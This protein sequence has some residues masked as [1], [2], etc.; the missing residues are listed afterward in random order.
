MAV[1]VCDGTSIAEEYLS[2]R[3]GRRLCAEPRLDGVND[4]PAPL[5][6]ARRTGDGRNSR[7]VGPITD[8]EANAIRSAL[9]EHDCNIAQVS[10][11][12]GVSRNKVYGGMPEIGVGGQVRLD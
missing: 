2:S 11:V 6:G 7:V 12:L 5:A 9:V 1:I 4:R 8:L 10:G 3:V